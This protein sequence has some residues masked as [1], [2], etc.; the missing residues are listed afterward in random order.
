MM[1]LP[2]ISRL[3]KCLIDLCRTRWT[4]RH[5]SYRHVYQAYRYVIIAP[6][7]IA[8]DANKEARGEDFAKVTWDTTSRDDA[9]SL[10][11]SLTSFNFVIC[12]LTVYQFLSHLEGRT[13]M[14]LQ[15]RT[16]NII[17]ACHEIAEVK[18]VY[19]DILR[20][21]GTKNFR[22]STL[23]PN[24]WHITVN[25]EPTMPRTVGRQTKRNNAPAATPVEYYRRNLAILFFNHI[26]SELEDQFSNL[27][28][29]GACTI[30]SQRHCTT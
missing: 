12:F 3:R 26:N 22:V 8:H 28:I 19:Q 1:A 24:E 21:M 23:K 7:Y 16:V 17:M 11:T 10:P 2:D 5:D 13:T 18:S 20:N 27:F 25:T 9:N 14:K 29:L 15:G 4:S 30:Y 6:E